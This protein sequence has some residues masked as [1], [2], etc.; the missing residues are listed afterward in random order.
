MRFAV[1]L[2][3]IIPSIGTRSIS[4]QG[5][6]AET[7]AIGDVTVFGSIR[8]R[9]YAWN[10]F[11]GGADGEYAYPGTLVRAGLS[12][13]KKTYDWQVEF[14]L[15]V[16]LNLPDN[17][18]K[19]GAPG[20]LGLGATYFAANDG[21][22][23]TAAL[24]VKQ[25]AIR[26]KRLAGVEGQSL[27]V[28]RLEFNDG[29]E[30]TPKNPTLSALKRD[31]ISQRL[32]GAFG[33]SDV[34]RSIDGVFYTINRPRVNVTALAGRPT[35]GAFQVDGWGELKTSIFYAA[36]T[37]QAG[38]E[39]NSGE[40]RVFALGYDDY[41]GQVVKTDNRPLSVRRTDAGSVA[42]G[43]YGGHYLRAVTTPIGTVDV[44][45]W[46]ALQSGSW[47]LLTHRARAFA[48][49]AGWQPRDLATLKPW[50]RGGYDYGSGD[51]D[52]S[53]Q[54]HGTYFQVLPTP[55]IYA[56][57]PFFNMM[58]SIDAFGETI[59][60]PATNVTIRADVHALRLATAN[61]LWYSGGGAFQPGTFGFTGRPSSGHTGLATLYDASADYR[62]T[63]HVA[64]ALY[65]G[66]AAGLP[67][68][69]AIYSTGDS[70]TG[71]RAHLGYVEALLRF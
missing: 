16:L 64:L 23:N 35:Q 2:S 5:N 11:G 14:A 18:V 28:G 51:A 12:R 4:A 27:T 1:L 25:A 61:D 68:T 29:A 26:F 55:R 54:V 53:D 44:L 46:G 57:F 49:E 8:T 59:L 19:P 48:A 56:R 31:R 70:S 67:V 30:V 45:A 40:W 47:G 42:I 66:Y 33:F 38:T 60:R 69:E 65:Y 6:A 63:A 52:P 39:A 22:T 50:F 62:V 15:P 37:R 58:N 10:W 41:R 36:L 32:L 21:K 20:Q 7:L 17:A 3:I 13:S 9:A 34:G 71:S 24:F 43:T